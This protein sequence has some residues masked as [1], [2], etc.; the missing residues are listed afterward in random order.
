MYICYLK[1]FHV[2]VMNILK[3]FFR[4]GIKLYFTIYKSLVLVPW[5]WGCWRVLC[6]LV[7][8]VL[9]SFRWLVSPC[10]SLTPALNVSH[11]ASEPESVRGGRAGTELVAASV[12][13]PVYLSPVTATLSRPLGLL[14]PRSRE[15]GGTIRV[16]HFYQSQF[17]CDITL[18]QGR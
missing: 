14:C 13:C 5:A 6:I 16:F 18:E 15:P 1:Y 4:G 9:C 12:E 8:C 7:E 3:M 10:L 2:C 11:P 17:Y